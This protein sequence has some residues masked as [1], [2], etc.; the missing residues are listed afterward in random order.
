M[1]MQDVFRFRPSNINPPSLDLMR[2]VVP[3]SDV[4]KFSSDIVATSFSSSPPRPT[5]TQ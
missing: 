1:L 5:T 3:K 2:A 4:M